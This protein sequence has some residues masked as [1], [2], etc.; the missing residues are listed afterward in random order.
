MAHRVIDEHQPERHFTYQELLE[1]Y[2]FEP[3][4][5]D[6]LGETPILPKDDLLKDLLTECREW[7]VRYHEHDSLLQ[8]QLNE[9]LSEEDRKLAWAEYEAEKQHQNA[10]NNANANNANTNNVSSSYT[11]YN[12]S[13]VNLVPLKFHYE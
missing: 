7:I 13:K 5:W 8:N 4:I 3:I 12:E 10:S 6:G 9:G 1:L 11:S 2:A